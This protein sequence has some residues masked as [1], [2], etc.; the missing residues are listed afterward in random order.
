MTNSDDHMSRQDL[1]RL[2]ID[3]L[4]SRDKAIA[5]KFEKHAAQ[6]RPSTAVMTDLLEIYAD[7]CGLSQDRATAAWDMAAAVAAEG[8]PGGDTDEFDLEEA[9]EQLVLDWSERTDGEDIAPLHILTTLR[10]AVGMYFTACV[11]NRPP[12]ELKLLACGI[13]ARIR[14]VES[15]GMEISHHEVEEFFN[16]PWYRDDMTATDEE[17]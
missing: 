13:M 12:D 10:I 17:P 7:E 4:A 15:C 14:Y 6:L 8:H 1:E 9:G 3:S 11:G 5:K 16:P 2:V